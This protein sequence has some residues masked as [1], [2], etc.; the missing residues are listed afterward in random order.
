V[1]PQH[2]TDEELHSFWI[3]AA[4]RPERTALVT[5]DEREVTAGE[6]LAG[7]H[8]LA[9][10]LRAR[11]LG[12]SD[13]VVLALPN[14][15]E[16]FE[17][18]LAAMQVGWYITPLNTHLTPT[19]MAHVLSDSGAGVLIAHERFAGQAAAAVK[20]A[21]LD[22]GVCLGVGSV[23]GFGDYEA[24][25]AQQSDARPDERCAG[26]MLQYTSG[27]TGR[28]KGVR[29]DVIEMD[30]DQQAH[31]YGMQLRKF[32]ITPGGDGVHLCCSPMYHLA[33]LAY[34]Y[35]ALHYEHTVVVMDGWTPEKTLELIERYRVTTTQMV[36]TQFHRLLQLPDEVRATADVSSLRQVLHA[37]AACPVHVKQRMLDWW[38]PVLYEYYGASEGGG[39]LV[40]PKEWLERP[41]TVGRPWEGA[42]VR[43]Y[44]DEGNQLGPNEI[45]NV[46]LKLMGEFEYGGDPEKTRAARIGDYFTAGDVGYLDDEGWLFLRD[47]KIDMII[48]GGVNIYPAEVEAALLEHPAVGDVA[49]FGIPDPDWGES[50]KAVVEPAPGQL[51]GEQLER[52]LQAH[53]ED[54]LAKYKRPRSIDFVEALPRDPNGKLYKRKLRDPYWEGQ[55]RNI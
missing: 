4:A 20:E 32:D 50:V 39:T 30:P 43:I 51:A 53:C 37:G 40:K 23:P 47:R 14:G 46:Y 49:V 24:F 16:F 26:Q 6:L 18:Y 48:S 42:D 38:G 35:F 21:G 17:A 1:A 10:G 25:K 31:L 33:P 19:E 12:R 2:P 22:P 45:G 55:E 29:R 3:S 34:A 52:S 54:R 41:G 8:Q 13:T 11:G 28:P 5:P 44:D 9:N 15:P 27:T 36:P 7:C